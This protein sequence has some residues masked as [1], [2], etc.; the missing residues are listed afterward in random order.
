MS[1][2][3][4]FMSD[5]GKEFTVLKNEKVNDEEVVDDNKIDDD[6]PMSL[7]D[8]V[9]LTKVPE[10]QRPVISKLVESVKKALQEVGSLKSK[11]DIAEALR[12]IATVSQNNNKK[13][14][15]LPPPKKRLADELKF[16][17]DDYY[18]PFFTKLATAMD[19]LMDGV[20]KLGTG[21]Q[22]DKAM[23]FQEK[24]T[25]F[26]KDNK[27]PTN[28]IAKMDEIATSMGTG[29]YND[30]PRLRKLAM[31]ELG[32]REVPKEEPNS[33]QKK[34]NNSFNMRR[35]NKTF[36]NSQD[37]PVKTMQDAMDKAMEQLG[38]EE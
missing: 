1:G 12:Q 9:D 30:L 14:D 2:E 24:V 23:T 6:D 20:E 29:V 11:A 26:V 27:V 7:I 21:V 10:D 3:N 16:E 4:S 32:I 37:K 15:E 33:Q 13:D 8:K 18:A 35:T 17:K 34:I 22:K 28:V 25:N 19:N 36:G 5:D 31:S 38:A